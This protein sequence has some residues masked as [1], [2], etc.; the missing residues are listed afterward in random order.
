M[1][2]IAGWDIGGTK[3]AVT[4]ARVDGDT[5][6]V[7]GKEKTPTPRTGSADGLAL[8]LRLLETAAEKAGVNRG[9]IQGVGISCGGPLDSE[10]GLIL[11]PPNLPG[12]DAVPI[13]AYLE[14]RA[15]I[16]AALQNDADACALAEWKYGAGRG[17]RN[18]VFLTF[19]T[20]FGA[21]LILN[22]ALYSGSNGMAGE[23]GHIRAPGDSPYRPVGYGK[24]GSLE[25]FCSGG[26]IAELGRAM[27][28]EAMQRGE[29]VSF[30][31]SFTDLDTLSAKSIAEAAEAGDPLAKEV[32]A[33]SGRRL[34]GALAMLVD[35]LNP[36]T[37]VIG[38]IYARSTALLRDAAMEVLERES[39][40]LSRKACQILPAA[41]GE[42]LGDAAALSLA[43]LPVSL[44]GAAPNRICF[45]GIES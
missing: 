14:E 30:C 27:A 38:S 12:W 45:E 1:A 36:E 33:C 26:G 17:C 29:A 6:R 22:G 13:K 42:H 28:L 2:F 5:I 9:D 4:L 37:I 11:S 18:M 19:G 7:I 41:L 35:L 3:L 24:S 20:G 15:G 40:P 44:G 21:G 34:G 31:P 8:L 39:L 32:Y 25:G 43:P 10:K 23:I 16:P